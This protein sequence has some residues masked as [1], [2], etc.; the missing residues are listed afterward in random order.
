MQRIPQVRAVVKRKIVTI[1]QQFPTISHSFQLSNTFQLSHSF[2][3]SNTFQLSNSFPHNRKEKSR[4]QGKFTESARNENGAGR[5]FRIRPHC[6]CDFCKQK[7]R[8]TKLL[9]QCAIFKATYSM[10]P[11]FSF[12]IVVWKTIEKLKSIEKL[13]TVEKLKSIEKLKTVENR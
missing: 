8:G 11:V 1:F 6:A 13:K 4:A 9:T 10:R 12:L 2:Q 3:L 7:S 5:V